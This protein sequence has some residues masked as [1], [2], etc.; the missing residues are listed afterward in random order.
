M[1]TF[2]K[3]IFGVEK[4]IIAMVHFPPLPGSPLYDDEK[5]IREIEEWVKRDLENLQAAGVDAVMF[6]NEGDRPYILSSRRARNPPQHSLAP[7]A[8]PCI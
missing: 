3:E 5:G 1:K 8:H 6:C 7:Y 4:V 2:L